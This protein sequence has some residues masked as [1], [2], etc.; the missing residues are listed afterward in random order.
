LNL[1][2]SYRELKDKWIDPLR[3]D[4]KVVSDVN[5]MKIFGNIEQL[6]FLNETLLKDLQK[7]LDG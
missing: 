4:G 2:E 6:I 3:A 5:L 1:I 7:E